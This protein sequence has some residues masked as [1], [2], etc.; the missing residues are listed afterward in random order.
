[1][2]IPT[3]E[4][5]MAPTTT[6][7]SKGTI[8]EE[9]VVVEDVNAEEQLASE[10]L[11]DEKKGHPPY[12][13]KRGTTEIFAYNPYLAERDDMG[14]WPWP[15]ILKPE[16]KPVAEIEKGERIAD[17]MRAIGELKPTDF[18]GNGFPKLAAIRDK[19]GY[20]VSAAERDE[21][22]NLYRKGAR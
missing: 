14:P 8:S 16:A 1:M 7:Y 13:R 2:P 6:D 21:A 20:I 15:T 5:L 18:S 19:M 10:Q 4:D 12:L 11:E 22:F 9:P 17:I 3:T